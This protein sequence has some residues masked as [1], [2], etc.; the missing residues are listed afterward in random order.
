MKIIIAG[1][2]EVGSHVAKLL[3]NAD[4]DVTILDSEME[5]LQALDSHADLMTIFGHVTSVDDLLTAKVDECDLFISVPPFESLSIL[6]AILA[7]KLGAK[8]TIARI[9]NK[10]YLMPE[11]KAFF[12]N[13]GVDEMIYPEQLA[14]DE[15]VESLKRIGIRQ[16]VEFANG[17]LMVFAVKLGE[18]AA[19]VGKTIHEAM[20]NDDRVHVGVVAIIR[21]TLTLI[22]QKKEKFQVGDRV[23]FIATKQGLEHITHKTG[24]KPFT[25]KNVMIMGGSRIGRKIAEE[26]ENSYRLKLIEADQERAEEL[27][28]RLS[29]TLIIHG[30]GKSAELMKEEGISNIDA[31]IAVT[32]NS[33]VNILACQLAKK[34]G[35]RKTVAEIENL[36]YLD[37]AETIGIGTVVNKKILAASAIF[38]FTY[39]RYI[40]STKWLMNSEAEVLELL[41]EPNSPITQRKI[42]AVDL[43]PDV[44]IGGIIRG[45]EAYVANEESRVLEGDKVVVF[46]HHKQINAIEKLFVTI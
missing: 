38:K 34:L 25:V 33:E 15:I 29:N 32:G 35:V 5:R 28:D 27:A 21:G 31:F 12:K 22:P 9:N 39:D 4:H 43:P 16:C 20:G 36:D 1:A 6:S 45:K 3:C 42:G 40:S 46:A 8:F 23:Y 41:A 13:L 30:D 10:E 18:S 2:G 14:T 19:I 44:N 11:T 7:K 24:K 37:F 17:N 26:I